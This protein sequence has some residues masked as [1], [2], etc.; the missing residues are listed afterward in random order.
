[1][2]RPIPLAL[3]A[4]T[5]TLSLGSCMQQTLPETPVQPTPPA[6]KVQLWLTTPDQSKLLS[7]ETQLS[8]SRDGSETF[9]TIAVNDTVTYQK[10]EGAGAAFT[11]SSAY[12]M[13]KM[14]PTDRQKLLKDLF[15]AQT[16]AGLD[17]AR[18]PIGASDFALSH[19]SFNDLAAG[20]TDPELKKFSIQHDQEYI[21]PVIKEAIKVNPSLKFMASPWSAPGWM[22]T[23]GSLIKGKLKP[24]YYD[25]YAQYF[26][27]YLQA[28]RQNGIGIDTIT[29]QNEPQHEPGDYPGMR[30]ESS[31]Q[32][33]FVGEHLGPVIQK[34][35][36]GTR[37]LGWDH[38]WDQWNYPIEVL[39]DPKARAALSGIAFHCYGGNVAAQSQ[40]KDSFPEKD[41]Y[42]TEC[43]G[44]FWANNFGDNLK[45]NME[46]LL[47]GA[48]RN[49]AKTV[50]LWN[51]ALDE[52][53]GPHLGG[54]G[55]CRGVVTIR[56][57]TGAVEK[58]V[59]YYV[60]GHYGKAVRQGAFRIAS[61]TYNAP[62]SDL[63]SVA[64]KN[65]DGSK[66]LI[67]LNSSASALTFKVKENGSSFYTTLPAG[68]VATYRWT[69]KGSDTPPP[70]A[71]APDA[72]KIVQAEAF[73]S[74]QGIQTEACQD[75]GG[76]LNVG[77]VDT[78][79]H[80]VFDRI[81]FGASGAKGVKFRV[82]SGGNGGTIQL[83]TGSLD[84]PV[85]AE[86]QVV[87]TG[88]WQ[89]WTTITAPANI[90]AGIQ[91]IYLVF[92]KA[93]GINLNWMQFTP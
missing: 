43:S 58:N 91:K 19:Y 15:D 75:E 3:T 62:A 51:L 46:N 18:I 93:D 21:I 31:E 23:S 38:N 1:M 36:L 54:C 61:N 45:W 25:T 17:H 49:W 2:P 52:K 14:S 73:S 83:R 16:G 13:S 40:I 85:V 71:P 66:A 33:K 55:N 64:F 39:N 10:M 90:P 77:Y 74:Q 65:P 67:V 42:F 24:E 29:V 59:E 20:E 37:I 78:G 69:G 89:N 79:D 44:G 35:G 6:S 57:D 22:K 41:L 26:V 82:A 76:G 53:G 68:A 72:F 56:S 48:T 9:P 92:S 88:G 50:L 32:A 70:P 30:M 80:L 4:I 63:Q 81:D 27:K 34:S 7:S 60:L 87:N 47:I 84:G 12:L 8:F 11:D 28:Y 5:L 86:A